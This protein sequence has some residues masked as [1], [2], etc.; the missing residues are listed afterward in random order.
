MAEPQERSLGQTINT[1]V[2]TLGIILAACWGVY[3]F[4]TEK[5]HLPAAAEKR[6]SDELDRAINITLDLNLKEIGTARS[7][8]KAEKGE[9]ALVAIEMKVSA[10]NPSSRVVYLLPNMW[11]ARGLKIRPAGKGDDAAFNKLVITTINGGGQWPAQLYVKDEQPTNV[12]VG[13]L[14]PDKY[15]KPGETVRRTL[16]FHILRDQYDLVDVSTYIPTSSEADRFIIE[17]KMNKDAVP[18]GDL[19]RLQEG[20]RELMKPDSLGNFSDA[21]FFQAA[22]SSAQLSLWR[23]VVDKK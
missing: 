16:I 12:A 13:S 20:K 14:F 8:E 4:Y 7:G 21:R 3:T 15:L 5:I 22:A 6:H 17:W 10:T 9:E 19:Y 2:Q 23:D 18:V 1:W 11:M